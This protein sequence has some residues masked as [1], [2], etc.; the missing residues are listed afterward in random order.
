[1]EHASRNAEEGLKQIEKANVA[2]SES[3]CIIS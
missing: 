2:A 3:A 1:M